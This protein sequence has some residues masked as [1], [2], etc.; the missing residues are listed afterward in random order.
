MSTRLPISLA[1]WDYDR[2]R[3]LQEGRVVPDGIDLTYVQIPAVETFFRM[4]RNREFDVAELSLSSYVIS[5]LD[6]S[7]FIAI[8]VFPSRAFRHNSIYVRSDGPVVDPRDLVGATVGIPEYQVTAAVWIRGILAERHEVPV[9]SVKYRIGGLHNPGRVEKLKLNL[10]ADIDYEQIPETHTLNEMLVSGEID[11]L[12]TP[13]TPNAFIERDP[14]VKRLFTDSK[15]AEQSYYRETGIFPIMHTIVI[16]RDLYEQHPWLAASLLKAFQESKRLT[17]ERLG[18]SAAFTHMLPWL[19]DHVEEAQGLM[20]SDYWPYGVDANETVLKAF[21]QYSYD[22]G[23][24]SRLL[25]VRELFA[26]ETLESVI[27]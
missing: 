4:V 15:H 1:C 11:A 3:A 23:L 22:Q 12:Y 10:P 2:T 13:R 16:R 24:S 20:G 6:D 26:P 25:D 19:Y 27:I 5:L 21:L 17:L 18:Q 7:P 14:A 8:P 9:S